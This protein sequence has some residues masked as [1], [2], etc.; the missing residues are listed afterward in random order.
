MSARVFTIGRDSRGR[1]LFLKQ[2]GDRFTLT[3]KAGA[4]E[5]DSVIE[6]TPED[7]RLIAAVPQAAH[8][9]C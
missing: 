6:L 3:R 4:R 8:A 5:G 7:I 2:D 9:P 1:A